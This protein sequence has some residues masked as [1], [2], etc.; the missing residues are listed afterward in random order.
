M[1]LFY[2]ERVPRAYLWGT[3]IILMGSFV[4]RGL[5]RRQRAK[6]SRRKDQAP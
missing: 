6:E 2:L 1:G 4:I 3:S 5:S